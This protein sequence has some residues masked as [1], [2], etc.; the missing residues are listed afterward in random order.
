[1]KKMYLKKPNLPEGKVICAAVAESQ[2]DVISALE[3]LGIEILKI[4]ADNRLGAGVAEH[5]DMNL[6]HLGDDNFIGGNDV[7]LGAKYPDDARLNATFIGN[8]LIAGKNAD[9]KITA[10]AT[11][12][13]IEIIPVNQGYTKCNILIIEENAFI[14]EDIGIKKA[15]EKRGIDVLLIEPGKITLSGFFH[16]FIGGAGGK[17]DKNKIALTGN[18]INHPDYKNIISF[19]SKYNVEPVFLTDRECFDIGGILPIKEI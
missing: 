8:Y 1:M 6:I 17:I 16:G 15:A 12:N 11:K 4:K 10:Y 5:A 3:N 19:F 13:Q 7:A 18:L 9:E 2:R 14:T